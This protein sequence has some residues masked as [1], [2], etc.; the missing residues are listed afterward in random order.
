MYLELLFYFPYS[1]HYLIIA[2]LYAFVYLSIYSLN[3][4]CIT[5]ALQTLCS[6]KA[7]TRHSNSEQ[8]EWMQPAVFGWIVGQVKTSILGF[9]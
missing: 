9:T 8:R 5:N 2:F 3:L 4:S 6:F 1:K 7:L